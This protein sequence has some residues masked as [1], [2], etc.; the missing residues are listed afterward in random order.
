MSGASRLAHLFL[1]YGTPHYAPGDV[2]AQ[3]RVDEYVLT[4]NEE[5]NIA[6]VRRFYVKQGE[7]ISA[8]DKLKH[9]HL[10]H[11]KNTS[12]RQP[13]TINERSHEFKIMFEMPRQS[14]AKPGATVSDEAKKPLMSDATTKEVINNFL[15]A[16]TCWG[17]TDYNLVYWTPL[18]LA[19]FLNQERF[20]EEIIKLDGGA[21]S[22]KNDPAITCSRDAR[23]RVPLDIAGFVHHSLEPLSDKMFPMLSPLCVDNKERFLLRKLG[24]RQSVNTQLFNFAVLQALILLEIGLYASD[25]VVQGM[26]GFSFVFASLVALSNYVL[27]T[28][29]EG[30]ENKLAMW[31][32][33][34]TMFL[35]VI[36]LVKSAYAGELLDYSV[37]FLGVAN[38][39]EDWRTLREG[40]PY[41]CEVYGRR[42]IVPS[43]K[44]TGR[45]SGVCLNAVGVIFNA[46]G[47]PPVALSTFIFGIPG[48]L[49]SILYR[50]VFWFKF[51]GDPELWV[52]HRLAP[53]EDEL[54]DVTRAK[55]R[56]QAYLLSWFIT[57]ASDLT[58]IIVAVLVAS[59]NPVPLGGT[60]KASG[61]DLTFA[62]STVG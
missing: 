43:A 4:N 32:S 54:P 34:S 53:F 3:H 56:V 8:L 41:I 45:A 46:V 6:A 37:M 30:S 13:V 15:E 61:G 44:S 22:K 47:A 19:V 55:E 51:R 20:A 27:P 2:E 23:G 35:S 38:L 7:V 5:D 26:C 16:Q 24:P 59:I 42:F 12:L 49:L 33:V 60:K 9:G 39:L 25:H 18:H 57:I 17:E 52:A 14:G 29:G 50:R 28:E 11:S 36:L 10:H 21:L 58:F 48:Y 40:L 62:P 1:S 31:L